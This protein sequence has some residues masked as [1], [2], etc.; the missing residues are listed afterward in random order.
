MTEDFDLVEASIAGIHEAYLCRALSCRELVEGY[1]ERIQAYDAAGPRLNCI[2]TVN[3]D[4]RAQAAELDAALATGDL[5]G[6]LH[7][8]P[9]VVKDQIDV[10][11]MPTTM[12]STLFADYVPGRDSSV[13]S[14]LKAA[15]ALILAKTTLGELGAGDTHGSLFG[16]TRNPYRLEHTPGG[17][18]GGSAVAV[19]ANLTT[20]ALGQEGLA[21]ITRPSAWNS[22][23]GMRPTA[24][25][26]SRA[27]AY[28][29]W[30]NRASSIGPMARTVEDAARLLD[31]IAGYDPDDPLTAT[32]VGHLS[33]PT[34]GQLCPKALDGAR[35]GV[36]RQSIGLG[37]EPDSE[38]FTRVSVVFDRAIADLRAAGA[39]VVDPVE[40]PRLQELLDQRAFE[41][42]EASFEAWMARS[43]HPP[44][45]SHAELAAQPAYQDLVHRRSGGHLRRFGS[46]SH[47]AYLRARDELRI[48]L[49]K[50]MADARLDVLVLKSVEHTATP[51]SEGTAPPF[52]D[53][54]GAIHLATFLIDVPSIT[55][56]A[57]ATPDGLPVGLSFLGR[58][59]TDAAVL[60]YAYAYEQHT[61]RRRPPEGFPPLR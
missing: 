4:V 46:S 35:V 36:L 44:Y 61:R 28:S 40:V 1:L 32:G 42:A 19:A 8:I 21:S 25:L 23:V 51:I 33:G 43:E 7:G 47:Y 49:L 60:G 57:G 22:I 12:G 54:K 3:P 5:A 34:V 52:T 20:A 24:G 45:R 13:V 26:V 2:I 31:V 14:R 10:A 38:D 56:P 53:G 11:G 16:S 30:P 17:S 9:I 41:H 6:P 18:S 27:G 39:I 15:G 59:F 48:N 37:S 55:V 29:G 58:P 50:V